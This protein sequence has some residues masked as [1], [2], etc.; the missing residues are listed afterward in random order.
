M[1]AAT[2]VAAH[3]SRIRYEDFA[4]PWY[5]PLIEEMRPELGHQW[6]RTRAGG[7][8]RTHRKLWELSLVA[9]VY[10]ERV[11]SG[12]RVLGFGCGIEPLPAWFAA[13]G[14]HVVATDG[15]DESGQWAATGQHAD[16]AAQLPGCENNGVQFRQVDMND[17]PDDLL[18]GGFD[19]AWSTGSF[20]HI[21]GIDQGLQ[22]FCRQMACLRPGGVAVHTTEF[23]YESDEITLEASD[24][25][26]F[27]ERDFEDLA[28]RLTAQ[29]D[30]MAP[31]DLRPG[32]DPINQQVDEPP[33]EGEPH[34]KIKIGG[35]WRTTSIAIIATRG[36]GTPGRQEKTR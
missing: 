5:G 1:L 16:T 18:Q 21:G 12:G 26:L 13:Q 8:F 17:I 22:F 33:Y 27:R 31:L 11:G 2:T 36:D 32:D 3:S 29:G 14:A 15:A 20:E 10:K 9:Q 19:L 4:R 6:T 23:N 34:L 28:G 30:T 24:L 25:V 35:L 7:A